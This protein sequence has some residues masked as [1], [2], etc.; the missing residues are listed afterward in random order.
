MLL[1][2]WVRVSDSTRDDGLR[3]SQGGLQQVTCSFL[4]SRSTALRT[5]PS[6]LRG[7][8]LVT[9]CVS[10]SLYLGY[11]SL[12]NEQVR[13]LRAAEAALATGNP[14]LQTAPEKLAA[15]S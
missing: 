7:K 10:L 9:R 15:A 3:A 1:A 12:P 8:G 6:S 13:S 5:K 11:L 2:R 14:T 4:C